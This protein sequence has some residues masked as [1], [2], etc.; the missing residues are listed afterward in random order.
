MQGSYCRWDVYSEWNET[1]REMERIRLS[2]ETNDGSSP[3]PLPRRDGKPPQWCV[4]KG[5]ERN[6]LF[7]WFGFVSGDAGNMPLSF[8]NK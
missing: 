8:S 1:I 5:I 6:N 4:F 3:P 7:R 2:Q